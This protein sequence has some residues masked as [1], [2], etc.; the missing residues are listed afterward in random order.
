MT[1]TTPLACRG[2]R[3]AIPS[4]LGWP[5]GNL[6]GGVAARPPSVMGGGA[7]PPPLAIGGQATPFLS[8]FFFF[9]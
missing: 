7:R 3:V 5:E 9:F 4:S 6:Q 2:W 8:F 1:T